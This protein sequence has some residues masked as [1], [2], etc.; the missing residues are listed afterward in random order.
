MWRILRWMVWRVVEVDGVV[1]GVE[2]SEVDG[3][4]GSEVDGV[5]GGELDGVDSGKLSE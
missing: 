4:N 2:A 1:D 3:A 5:E